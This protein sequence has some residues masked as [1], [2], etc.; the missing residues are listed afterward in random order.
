MRMVPGDWHHADPED[1]AT[2]AASAA[3]E[4]AR[5]ANSRPRVRKSVG[6]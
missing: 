2:H 6:R 1:A 5:R 4:E 3:H